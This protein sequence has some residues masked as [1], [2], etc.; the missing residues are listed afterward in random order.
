MN[1]K[2]ILSSAT[3]AAITGMLLVWAPSAAYANE[4]V[5][6]TVGGG[7]GGSFSDGKTHTVTNKNMSKIVCHFKDVPNDTGA[8]IVHEGFICGTFAGATTDTFSIVNVDGNATLVCKLT[9]V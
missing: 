4:G 2:Q 7:P 1:R 5:P 3:I 8:D 6:A 9:F